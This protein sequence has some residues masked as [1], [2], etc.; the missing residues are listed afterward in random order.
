MSGKHN[1]GSGMSYE[2]IVKSKDDYCGGALTRWNTVCLVVVGLIQEGKCRVVQREL[3]K[4]RSDRGGQREVLEESWKERL[5]SP[6]K[7]R[8]FE[9]SVWKW[10]EKAAVGGA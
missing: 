1:F 7:G 4:G 8:N 10:C 2:E 6:R 5:G 3:L 9:Y